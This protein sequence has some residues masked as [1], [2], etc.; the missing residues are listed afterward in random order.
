[1][2]RF[3]FYI[4]IVSFSIGII[5]FYTQTDTTVSRL[6]LYIGLIAGMTLFLSYFFLE[7]RRYVPIVLLCFLGILLGSSY[8][9]LR[10]EY[11]N[12]NLQSNVGENISLSGTIHSYPEKVLYGTRFIL[13]TQY[14]NVLVHVSESHTIEYG[15]TVTVMGVVNLP[16]NF[17][18]DSGKEFDYVH[19]L[20]KD[21]IFFSLNGDIKTIITPDRFILARELFR[22]RTKILHL[23]NIIQKKDAQGLV[24]GVLIGEKSS[25]SKDLEDS[26]I[27]TG[28]IHILALSGYNVSIVALWIQ[29]FFNTFLSYSASVCF[30]IL[31]IVFFVLMTGSSSTAVR[32]GIMAI[33]VLVAKI[34]YRP[35]QAVRILLIA[36]LGMVVYNPTFLVY[37]ISFQLSFLAT[38]SLIFI[39][40]VLRKYF[41]WVKP[42]WLQSVVMS[43]SAA[44]I[45]TLPYIL[46]VMGNF[47]LISLPVN[48]LILPLI[49]ILML[50]G[51]LFIGIQSV[52]PF[53]SFPLAFAI[54]KIT[55]YITFITYN[56]QN[57]PF[58]FFQIQRVPLMVIVALYVCITFWVWRENKKLNNFL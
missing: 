6:F 49:P 8:G 2:R 17:M 45:G 54:E 46:F 31:G 10:R 44:Q 48:V 38:A 34:S 20:E 30:G 39:E 56:A 7:T 43:T 27:K 13:S 14:G 23:F 36:L 51:V 47:S 50:L 25:I 28:T 35:Y 52:F 16:K 18:T 33:L 53:L 37:D 4:C 12:Q 29:Q 32:A 40:P 42:K 24:E 15:D 21:S 57:I 55:S 19:Y 11:P 9:A 41:L 5:V 3:V 22:V 1:M 26:F 58:A